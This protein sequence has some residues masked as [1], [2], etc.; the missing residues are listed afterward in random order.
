M[1][2][3]T[4]RPASGDDAAALARLAALDSARV[5]AG[6]L[7]LAEVDGALCAAVALHDGSAIA[8]P[9]RPT[10]ALLELLHGRVRQLGGG[11]ASRRRI[12]SPWPTTARPSSSP[13][14][15][16]RRTGSTSRPICPAIP[17]PRR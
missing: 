14:T 16:S 12:R 17:H 11:G 2:T 5:P 9:F 6:P 4:I 10:V 7:L 8:D 15:T 3:V 13:P 1:T